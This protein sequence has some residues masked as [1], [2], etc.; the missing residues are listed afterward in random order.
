M[1]AFVRRIREHEQES[2][3]QAERDFSAYGDAKFYESAPS[4]PRTTMAGCLT[5]HV[6]GSP[7]VPRLPQFDGL[8]LRDY[9][10]QT[11]SAITGS[12]EALVKLRQYRVIYGDP[13][14]SCNDLLRNWM[15][16]LI[17]WS[18]PFNHLMAC[19]PPVKNLQRCSVCI[20]VRLVVRLWEPQISWTNLR[21]AY[22]VRGGTS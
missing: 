6:T 3:R 1:T 2:L 16:V 15:K 13:A 10:R 20:P 4:E 5:G 11:R 12:H 19:R 8:D 14:R 22:Q 17:R 18:A 21:S 7:S 9:L